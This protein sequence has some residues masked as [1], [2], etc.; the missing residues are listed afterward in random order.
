MLRILMGDEIVIGWIGVI[1]SIVSVVISVKTYYD[2]LNKQRKIDTLNVLSSIR[3]EYP[4]FNMLSNERK[5]EYMQKMEFLALGVHEGI[6][7][8]DIVKKMSRKRLLS[9]YEEV[10]AK[11]FNENNIK[12]YSEYRNLMEEIK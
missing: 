3:V 2:N 1:I 7:D 4:S 11:Y 9:Q 12:D 6:Y 5:L 8:I 10:V